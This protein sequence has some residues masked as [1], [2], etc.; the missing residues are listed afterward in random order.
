MNEVHGHAKSGSKRGRRSVA[1]ARPAEIDQRQ[2]QEERIFQARNARG[3]EDFFV[4]TCECNQQK[5]HAQH[6]VD[7]GKRRSRRKEWN[8]GI[9]E[10]GLLERGKLVR[11]VHK[12]C[13]SAK[14]GENASELKEKLKSAQKP[15]FF[16]N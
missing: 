9:G 2:H 6:A 10:R 16:G 8:P 11:L 3:G 7:C 5:S 13:H 1:D 4:R 12:V 15:G 14:K